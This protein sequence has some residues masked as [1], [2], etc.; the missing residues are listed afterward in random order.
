MAIANSELEQIRKA[1]ASLQKFRLKLLCPTVATLESGATDLGAAVEC[2]QRIEPAPAHRGRRS[3]GV[4]HALRL[5]V[6]GL[7]RD[8]QQVHALL[9]GAG[10]FYQGWSRLVGCSADKE[11]SNYTAHGKPVA[12]ISSASKNVVIHG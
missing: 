10:N 1:R 11:S 7:R 9:E 2:L 12:C 6:E 5:E 4:E 8:L 3:P